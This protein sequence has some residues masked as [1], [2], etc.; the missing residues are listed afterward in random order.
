MSDDEAKTLGSS[1]ISAVSNIADDMV[2]ELN[3]FR[4]LNRF[5]EEETGYL[6]PFVI[7]NIK[8]AIDDFYRVCESPIEML[9]LVKM[10]ATNVSGEA[11]VPSY[12]IVT[13]KLGRGNRVT[14]TPQVN[15][16]KYRA[17]FVIDNLKGQR[18]LVE[19]DGRNFHDAEGDA[20]RDAE[21][22]E[23][24]GMKTFRL[25]GREIWSSDGW[26]PMFG[27]WCR[28][29]LFDRNKDLWMQEFDYRLSKGGA[30]E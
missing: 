6:P 3:S 21:I 16:L 10:L 15:L 30:D 22:E 28:G 26:R 8:A 14:I 13:A 20:K 23:A 17:D 27:R 5:L 18:F 29:K 24:L 2:G 25:T 11:K 7:S 9:A 4:R 12:P 1:A 19:C